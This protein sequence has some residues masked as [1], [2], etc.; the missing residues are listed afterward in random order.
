M[1]LRLIFIHGW[2]TDSRV[3]H[4][5]EELADEF[6]VF[7]L[8]LPGHGDGRWRRPDFGPALDAL[9]G[10]LKDGRET[11]CIGWSLGGEI[12]L[13]LPRFCNVRGI[14]T[15]GSSPSF[16]KR[17]GFP[18]G[19]PRALVRKMEKELKRDFEGT[20]ERFYPLN[21]S[22]REMDGRAYREYLELLFSTKDSLIEEDV[23]ISLQALMNEDLRGRLSSIDK[24]VLIVHGT[25]DRVCPFDV[26]DY[27]AER[28]RKSRVETFHGAGHMPFLTEY[29]RFN[30]ILRGFIGEIG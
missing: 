24:P 5:Q 29:R 4:Y 1:S 30:S 25:E 13:S 3:W 26:A 23:V 11:L 16:V 22:D 18:F 17:D 6:E 14:V 27:L 8:N 20:L 19:Q 15:V 10:V 12:L 28:I 2:A 21:F 9:K 7:F